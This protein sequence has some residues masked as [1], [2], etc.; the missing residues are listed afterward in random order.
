MYKNNLNNVS[1]I[2]TPACF[3]TPALKL[4]KTIF[5]VPIVKEHYRGKEQIFFNTECV[6][7]LE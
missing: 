5:S 4:I 6:A 7:D 2:D 1:R 3:E